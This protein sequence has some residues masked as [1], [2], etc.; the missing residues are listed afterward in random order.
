LPT[1][2]TIRRFLELISTAAT[3]KGHSNTTRRPAPTSR[4]FFPATRQS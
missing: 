3:L 2:T 1:S 4:L